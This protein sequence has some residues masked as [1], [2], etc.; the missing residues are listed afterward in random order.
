MNVAKYICRYKLYI[1]LSH[2]I[3]N[4]S[5]VANLVTYKKSICI[6]E[7]SESYECYEAND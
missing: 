3:M 7:H 2:H 1:F 4:L 6:F 5:N